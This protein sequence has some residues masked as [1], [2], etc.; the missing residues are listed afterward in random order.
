MGG[1]GVQLDGG[2]GGGVQVSRCHDEVIWKLEKSGNYS[3]KSM[4]RLHSF[5]GLNNGK[6]KKL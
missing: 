6:L 5:T 4:Y 3:T 1:P 2:R